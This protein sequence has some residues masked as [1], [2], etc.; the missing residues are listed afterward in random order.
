[1]KLGITGPPLSGKTSLFTLM[2]GEAPGA[3]AQAGRTVTK[4]VRVPDPRLEKLRDVFKPKS[5]KPATVQLTDYGMAVSHDQRIGEERTAEA[6]I[7][8]LPAFEGKDPAAA[9]AD[10]DAEW[11]L[12]DMQTA[13]RRVEKI[14]ARLKRPIPAK[15]K[16]ELAKEREFMARVLAWVSDE[17]PLRDMELEPRE[18]ERIKPYGM[19]TLKPR[20]LI[21]NV[22]EGALPYPASGKAEPPLE[23]ALVVA[24]SLEAELA[25][26]DPD[27]RESFAG[28]YG[29]TELCRD[30]L[31]KA[32]NEL[33]DQRAFFTS[34]EDEVRAWPIQ[35][36]ATAW[37]A[38]GAIHSDIQ[39]GF[40]RAEV[41]AYDDFIACGATMKG[42]KAEKKLRLEGK[43]YV[44]QDADMIEF[45]FN[46]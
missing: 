15:E 43:D 46:V 36:G 33:L 42:V 23:E 5:Y 21:V 17:K 24:A 44:V 11:T 12:L 6:L 29:I 34:G 9:A 37:E 16:D 14:D 20:L 8:C 39:R 45:R 19:F 18:L 26:M 4:I 35:C 40:I 38:A 3:D 31:I 27:E 30:R 41:T 2:I 22:D 25:L 28:E 7:V 32:A 10:I 13:E 1:M